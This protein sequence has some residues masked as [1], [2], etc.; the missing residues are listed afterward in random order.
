M[1]NKTSDSYILVF[2]K[3]LFSNLPH[4]VNDLVIRKS[5]C[6]TFPFEFVSIWSNGGS[7]GILNLNC[8]LIGYSKI[9][10]DTL[11]HNTQ[12]LRVGPVQHCQMMKGGAQR[13]C[14]DSW[15]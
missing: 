6:R 3:P 7:H 9:P 15:V 14:F 13:N 4:A 8:M 12:G 11:S 10:S 1:I 2:I 5:N